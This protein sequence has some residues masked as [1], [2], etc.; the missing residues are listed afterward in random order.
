[1]QYNRVASLSNGTCIKI[2]NSLTC[3]VK[4]ITFELEKDK[5]YED[6]IM[7]SNVRELVMDGNCYSDN[8]RVIIK[9]SV[10]KD[11]QADLTF[12]INTFDLEDGDVIKGTISIITNVGAT[13]VDFEYK[14]ITN[15]VNRTIVKLKSITDY[16]DL[17]CSDFS[18]ARSLFT[19]DVFLKTPLLQ[20]DFNMSLY[21]G[22][23]KGSN[24]NIAIIEFFKAFGIDVSKLFI[25]VD[26]E[27]VKRYIDDTLDNIDISNIAQDSKLND[28]LSVKNTEY[29]EEKIKNEISVEAISVCKK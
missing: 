1:M 26:D 11:K 14:I 16:Y 20:E 29:V 2:D 4:S 6:H 3:R 22:L 13:N 10:I 24:T 19:H 25:D 18:F 21:E 27:I 15:N 9:N 28:A 23:I 17:M 7:I 12:T 8:N 5:K